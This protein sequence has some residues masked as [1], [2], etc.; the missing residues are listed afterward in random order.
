MVS[1]P[2]RWQ[3]WLVKLNRF[4]SRP[5]GMLVAIGLMILVVFVYFAWQ[6][7]GYKRDNKILLENAKAAAENSLLASNDLKKVLCEGIPD[8]DCKLAQAVAALEKSDQNQTLIM[9]RLF[10]RSGFTA[11][12]T[13][14]EEKQIERICQDEIH[15]QPEGGGD[16]SLESQ[17]TDRPVALSSPSVGGERRPEPDDPPGPTEEEPEEP[18]ENPPIPPQPGLIS[19]L[20]QQVM[21]ILDTLTS[22]ITN[23]LRG[24][25]ND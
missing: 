24:G 13:Q 23:L 17:A 3:L 20:A 19:N 11:E 25:D 7:V 21:G 9:C 12:L 8:E 16:T 5:I 2:G 10:F 14:E 1:N 22:P 4:F 18:G 6:D 15:R